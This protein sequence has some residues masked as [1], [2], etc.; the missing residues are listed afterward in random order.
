MVNLCWKFSIMSASVFHRRSARDG[1]AV[2]HSMDS[3]GLQPVMIECGKCKDMVPSRDRAH[4]ANNRNLSVE[5]WPKQCQMY[6]IGPDN[7]GYMISVPSGTS[8]DMEGGEH[9]SGLQMN[10][11]E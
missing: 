11:D 8:N 5:H 4:A 10:T 9:D 3:V 2:V 6:H 1:A 7:A